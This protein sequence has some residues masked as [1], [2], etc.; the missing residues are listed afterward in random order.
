MNLSSF[1]DTSAF[2]DALA[3][4]PSAARQLDG[5]THGVEHGNGLFGSHAFAVRD[6]PVSVAVHFGTMFRGQ[7]VYARVASDLNLAVFKI[8][9]QCHHTV[10][11]FLKDR[12]SCGATVG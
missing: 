10:C 6:D 12:R 8:L 1:L 2:G 9:V 3:H 7:P 4:H 5:E 11:D